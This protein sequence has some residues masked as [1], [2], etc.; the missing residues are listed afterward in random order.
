MARKALVVKTARHASA[1]AK[2]VKAGKKPVMP[3][4]VYHRCNL[5]GRNRGY[6]RAFQMC[7]ICFREKAS[8]GDIVGIRK[9]SW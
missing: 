4:K 7:R 1:V 8:V 9:A 5:C 3:T 2:A 6:L